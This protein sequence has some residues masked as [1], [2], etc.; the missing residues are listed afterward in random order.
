MFHAKEGYVLRH[1]CVLVSTQEGVGMS[2]ISDPCFPGPLTNNFP[3]QTSFN[4]S[5]AFRNPT[6]NP[7][8]ATNSA[9]PSK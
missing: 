8:N 7:W 4:N 6:L 3:Q 9:P 2:M 5:E 1:D